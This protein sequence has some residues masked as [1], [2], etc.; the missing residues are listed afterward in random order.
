MQADVVTLRSHCQVATG[1]E[2]KRGLTSHG[3]YIYAWRPGGDE[4][5]VPQ[6]AARP[7][8]APR[9]SRKGPGLAGS[10]GWVGPMTPG[11]GGGTTAGATVRLPLGRGAALASRSQPARGRHTP[12]RA[13]APSSWWALRGAG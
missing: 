2:V 5:E 3:Y 1:T 6:P 8:W 11:G 7:V 10:G 13:A 4:G 9:R 12:A